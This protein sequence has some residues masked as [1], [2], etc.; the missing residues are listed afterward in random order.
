LERIFHYFRSKDEILDAMADQ[1]LGGMTLEPGEGDSPADAIR[2]VA[3]AFRTM[4]REHPVVVR[5]LAG[6]VTD[7]QVALR[8]AM[9]AIPRW[10]RGVS[11]T[12]SCASWT[13][14]LFIRDASHSHLWQ[15]R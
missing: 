3:A 11:S 14:P 4:M 12:A 15:L 13:R 9:E 7:S 8:G 1:V 6:R 5:L 2:A 10:D